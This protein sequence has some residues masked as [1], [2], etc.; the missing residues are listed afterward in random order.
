MS[1]DKRLWGVRF[2]TPPDPAMM[3]L[4]WAEGSYFRLAPYD[5]VSLQTHAR[6]EQQ[7]GADCR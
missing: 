6:A 1:S 2:R 3:R 5:I 7:A 4:S